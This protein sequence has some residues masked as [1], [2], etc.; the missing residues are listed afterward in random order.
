MQWRNLYRGFFIGMT[1]LVPGVSGGTVAFILGIYNELLAAISGVFSR[2]WKKHITYLIPIGI[3]FGIAVVSL[4]NLIE[5][6][7][8]NYRAPMMFFFLGLI[9]G[10]LPF[11]A[12]KANIKSDF[13]LKHYLLLIAVAFVLS[14]V[15]LY[16]GPQEQV[17]IKKLALSN[18]LGLFF[19]GWVASMATIL[20]GVSGSFILLVLGYYGTVIGAL[21]SINI[22]IIAVVGLGVMTGLLVTSHLVNYALKRHPSAMFAGI[23]GL[24]ISS[25]FAVYP[26]IPKDGTFLVMSVL[27]LIT[28]LLVASL[29]NFSDEEMV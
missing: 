23:L 20:P 26:G 10:I 11:I 3:G 19:V 28:G 6:L 25:V 14:F 2:E 7:L 21:S 4:S 9:I 13:K 24:I 8:S 12:R 5:Y 18:F 15:I 29:F 17:T 1:D 22:P 16:V 27:A